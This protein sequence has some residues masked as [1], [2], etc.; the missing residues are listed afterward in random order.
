MTRLKMKTVT[1]LII[2]ILLLIGC[3]ANTDTSEENSSN[4][5]VSTEQTEETNASDANNDNDTGGELRVALNAQPPTLDIHMTTA[6]ATKET[7][8][9][10]YETLMTID[11]KSLAAPMLAESVDISEDGKTYTFRLREGIKFH[12]GE[13]MIAEDVV[14][15]MNRWKELA[16]AA[17]QAFGESTFEVEDDY[18]VVLE[19]EK[20]VLAA[21]DIIASPGQFAAIMPKEV[22]EA[23]GDDGVDEIIGTGPFQFVEWKQ[24]QYI[25]F[26]KFEDYQALDSEPDGLAGKKE[27][28]VDDVYFDIVTDASTRISG[29][30]AGEY[31]IAYHLPHD[32]YE[33][34]V[35][36]E[37]VIPLATPTGNLNLVYN[38]AS[39][40]V[41]DAKVRQ[42]INAALD[43]DKIMMAAF[44][45]EELYSLYAGYM[46]E[47]MVNWATEA[48]S[49]FYNQKDLEKA[50]QLLDEAG[51]NGEPIR[52]MT[53][54]DYL[55]Y[56][57]AAVVIQEQLAEIDVNID[58]QISDW[59]TITEKREDP[60][61]WEIFISGFAFVSNPVQIVVLSPG[62]AG[63]SD[64]PK[65]E[66]Q[67]AAIE[68]SES[69]EE[70]KEHWTELQS[71]LWEEYLPVTQLGVYTNLFAST[72][73]VEDFHAFSGAIF[74]NTKVNK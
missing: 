55:H 60:D 40:P 7:V 16:F 61:V 37:N 64:H 11:S 45:D 6:G 29:I 38:K 48:G 72:D 51:Y 9:L 3:S 47:T 24:D 68:S 42:A 58:L 49:E 5:D 52:L 57:K 1:F 20:P 22:I 43:L 46:D 67:F 8:R 33:Q 15:S 69:N 54:R 30:Q 63:S 56:Y 14:A 23:A 34:L 21:L 35:N 44:N 4:D 19:L 71:F 26:T 12:N 2:L 59:A 70:A 13:E 39:G 10:A 65:I 50:K 41:A 25:H 31:D 74:W 27:A 36:D 62:Y 53:T 17:K 28:L 32:S 66:E 73:K 18:T